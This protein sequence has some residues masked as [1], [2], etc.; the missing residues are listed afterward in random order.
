MKTNFLPNQLPFL[1]GNTYADPT[2]TSYHKT[3]LLGVKDGVITGT[4]TS[5]TYNLF[6]E[7]ATTPDQRRR[8]PRPVHARGRRR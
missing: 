2:V 4:F 1:P 8:L 7:D 3:Q 6:R 5:K